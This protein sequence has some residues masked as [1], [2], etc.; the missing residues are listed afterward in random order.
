MQYCLTLILQFDNVELDI[1]T[2]CLGE[3]NELHLWQRT[4]SGAS[5]FWDMSRDDK[6][7]AVEQKRLTKATLLSNDQELYE[8]MLKIFGEKP[9]TQPNLVCE[10]GGDFSKLAIWMQT[11]FPL[12]TR[13]YLVAHAFSALSRQLIY[14]HWQC[15]TT[16]ASAQRSLLCSF[17]ISCTLPAYDYRSRPAVFDSLAF[18]MLASLSD[19]HK[20]A[21]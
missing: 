10:T 16:F 5:S 13:P 18:G 15:R 11:S 19:H 20:T 12:C 3:F 9:T 17:K 14:S 8:L 2:K 4:R 6:H 1:S 21:L 7:E